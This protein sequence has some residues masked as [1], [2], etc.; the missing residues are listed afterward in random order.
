[1]VNKLSPELEVILNTSDDVSLACAA[2]DPDAPL[3]A[4]R[5]GLSCCY[6]ADVYEQKHTPQRW[7]AKRNA[8]R[9]GL[10]PGPRARAG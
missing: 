6:L 8:A 2:I 4:S 10:T 9:S 5:L 1:M 7:V 3:D